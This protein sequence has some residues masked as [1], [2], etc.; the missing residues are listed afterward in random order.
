MLTRLV[1]IA[2]VL[3]LAAACR[4][5]PHRPAADPQPA[6]PV[7]VTIAHAS[8]DADVVEAGGTV[9]GRESVLLA[10]RVMA[11]VLAVRVRAGERVAR[12]QVLVELDAADVAA[13]ASA[14]A[15]GVRAAERGLVRAKAE[16]AAAAAAVS[17]ARVTHTRMSVLHG[18]RSV[19]DQEFDEARA[20]L[21]AAE[22]RSA[23]AEAGVAAAEASLDRFRAEG[24]AAR[25]RESFRRI[26]A[27]FSGV[28]TERLVD[29]GMLATP[30]APL[31][32]VEDVA[33]FELDVRVDES[34]AAFVKLGDRVSVALG[35]IAGQPTRVEGRVTEVAR[36]ATVEGRSLALTVAFAATA[37]VTPGMFARATLPGPRRSRLTVPESA[38]SRNGQL[39]SVFVVDNDTARLRLVRLGTIAR[40]TVEVVAG[41]TDGERVVVTPA[42]LQDGRRVAATPA[43]PAGARP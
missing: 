12:G 9:R 13:E 16:A 35:D 25:A 40:G 27:P 32:R 28:V 15:A 22:A 20:A 24:D 26:T 39:T 31:L 30:G 17:L 29:V 10:S 21:E 3:P 7:T 36:G 23:A 14:S 4:T 41:L 42:S 11:P 2:A 1:R 37:G 8:D 5:A 33:G 6:V 34:R 18:R 38:I 19:T 43:G